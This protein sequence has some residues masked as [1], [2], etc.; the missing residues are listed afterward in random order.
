MGRVQ[1]RLMLIIIS[2]GTHRPE[3][4]Y[5][6]SYSFSLSRSIGQVGENTGNEV[7]TCR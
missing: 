3:G 7:A 4:H 2:C 6:L 1:K 5:L